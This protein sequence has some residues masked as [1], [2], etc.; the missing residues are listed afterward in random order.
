[1]NTEHLLYSHIAS[2][3]SLQIENYVDGEEFVKLTEAE[4]KEMVP[5]IGIAKKVMRLQPKVKIIVHLLCQKL[6]L[7]GW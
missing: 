1:M 4:I 6:N 2:V 5:P 7:T 3:F